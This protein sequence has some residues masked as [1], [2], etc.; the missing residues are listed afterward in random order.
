ML[1]FCHSSLAAPHKLRVEDPTLTKVLVAQGAKV[2]GDYGTFSVLS[3]ED[4][5][6]ANGI[7][8]RVEVADDW[9]LI[10]LNSGE[11]DTRASEMKARRNV[12]GV[13]AGKKL[14]LVQF[15]G[16]VK[17][18]WLAE[19]KQ[20]GVQIVS[21][22]PENAY[23]IYGDASAI[24]RMQTWAGA[25]DFMQ[26]EGEY[27]Q[28]LKVHSEARTLAL[29]N[30]K[31]AS[32][33]FAI[34]L[35]HDT[36]SNPAT[37]A[38]INRLKTSPVQLDYQMSPYRNVV[39]SLPSDQLDAI[40]AQSDVISIQ[41][42]VQPTKR[43]ERQDQIVAGNLSGTVPSGP[44][45]L[46][47]LASKG[48]TQQQFDDSG[49]VVDV[50]D[51]GVD[52]GSTTPGHFGFYRLG[53]RGSSS[54][55]AYARLEGTLNAGG[56]LSGC[57][58]HGALN[59]HIIGNYDGFTGF[60]HQDSEGF[61]YGVGICPFVKIGSSVIFDNSVLDQD[62]TDP[63]FP[64]MA[65]D[66]YR[67]G[68]RVSNNS[69]GSDV[70]GRYDFEAQTYDALVRDSQ[71]GVGGNQ[72]MSFAF[73]AGNAG[74]CNAKGT[75]AG[76]DSPGSAKNVITVGASENVRSLSIING[77][78]TTNGSDTCGL[79]D[80]SA[81]S[82]DD[83]DCGSSRGPCKDGRM[84]PDIVAPGIHITGGVPQVTPPPSPSGT[85]SAIS[86]FDSLG[87]CALPGSG[88]PG[89]ANNFFPLGQQFYT[90]SSGTSHATP[91]VAGACA[92]VRQYFI[93]NSLNAPS[94]AMTKAF[95]INSARYLTGVGANDSLWSKSQGMGEVNL[96]VAFDGVPRFLRD[97]VAEDKFT[98]T[99]QRRGFVGQVVD[100]SKP[101][102]VTL[103]WTDAPGSTAGAA[104]N[105]NLD[106][107]V[108]VGGNTY[109]GNVFKGQYSTVGGKAD[110]KNN[111]ESVFLPP[112]LSG[113]LIVLVTAANINSDGVPNEEPSLD[114]DFALVV[115][116]GTAASKQT[117]TPVAAT[118]GGLFYESSGVALGRSGAISLNTTTSGSYSGKLQIGAK[119]YAFSGAFDPFGV[120][121]NA[122]VRA[123]A[124]TLGLALN[125]NLA[126][127][128]LITGTISDP[129]NW[130][131]DVRAERA[132]SASKT[133][134]TP[135]AGS[136]TLIF[137]G[138][139]GD[140]LL[141]F[142]DGYGTVAVSTAGKITFVGSLADGTKLSQSSVGLVTAEWPLYVSLYGG[143]GQILGW[144]SFTNSGLSGDVSWIKGAMPTAKF[145]SSGFDFDTQATGSI[146]NSKAVPLID[147]TSG[148]VILT[149]G[150][151][152]SAITSGLTVNGAAVTGTNKLSFKLS[153]SKGSF[154]GSVPNPPNKTGIP[155][156]GVFLQNQNFG[157]GYFLGTNQ[158]GRVFFGQPN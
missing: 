32:G 86:C 92:L 110:V 38:L 104:Y 124:S 126:D 80:S 73:A 127:N 115:Y 157:S 26:W 100:S 91:V 22:I 27:G 137:P 47:W 17:P 63:D 65:S 93:N 133:N 125:I 76:I 4:A 69:W 55:V 25:S 74:P 57:D 70:G 37:L 44:G 150:N 42:F 39:V 71:S 7:S 118:Y 95:L 56:T 96:G 67:D 119:S 122:I 51:S 149:G 134:Q 94:P 58:G 77:G 50:A 59:G 85:G 152:S 82:A 156:S 101:L 24:S 48:F 52:N 113:D 106:L 83:I 131:A 88:T 151:L 49:L 111:V 146:Y 16:P 75:T 1:A 136:Y 72:E 9:N 41:P 103:A 112:G 114:Q 46:A 117:V 81:N 121:T 148:V 31:A 43:D 123:G 68:A 28:E 139:N 45:Y 3:A 5:L 61:S 102:R 143:Q 29:N 154:N 142:G 130:T 120:A 2:I 116:N 35:I 60:Q 20:N 158:S 10:R 14:H 12:R 99:G 129:G 87:V 33:L 128:D 11:L 6:L 79:T 13:F 107:I 155:F 53:N 19:L 138:T 21:Y 135:F 36:N 132:Q 153:A 89:N 64:T 66:A 15:A 18:G 8:N 145:Y 34:Q 40:A 97:Q 78:V 108:I 90:E 109:K 140:A 144:L 23:L 30:G 147:F 98:G 62:F 84:K 141:P 105:N 54:R